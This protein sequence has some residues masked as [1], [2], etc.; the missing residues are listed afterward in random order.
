MATPM[1]AQEAIAAAI[2]LKPMVI[3]AEGK[4]VKINYNNNI[5]D[6]VN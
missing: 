3:I 2:N 5:G 6:K 4:L 1:N